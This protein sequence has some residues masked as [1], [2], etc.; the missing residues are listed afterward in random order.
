MGR[1]ARCQTVLVQGEGLLVGMAALR[2]EREG[3]TRKARPQAVCGGCSAT[4]WRR[5]GC[6]R[7]W[8]RR[9]AE[10]TAGAFD[11]IDAAAFLID[12]YGTVMALSAVAATMVSDARGTGR[13]ACVHGRLGALRRDTDALL[14]TALGRA[15]DGETI[16]QHWHRIVARGAPGVLCELF[17]LRA[18]RMGFRFRPARSGGR[19]ARGGYPAARAVPLRAAL[20]LTAAEAEIALRLAN[21][22][23]REAIAAER[24]TSAQTLGTQIKAILRKGDVGRE[25]ELTALVNRLL[26]W[27]QDPN[28]SAFGLPAARRKGYRRRVASRRYPQTGPCRARRGPGFR[29]APTC[30]QPVR[31]RNIS[32]IARRHTPGGV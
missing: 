32:D 25:A 1:R 13:C 10:M 28:R 17:R 20:G 23:A 24:G 11:A 12:R 22:E 26:R 7:R 5:C 29:L 19:A 2:S 21:G 18:P 31:R 6:G 14:Q 27:V 3:L 4:R 8:R 16:Q 9:G 15:L 30:G